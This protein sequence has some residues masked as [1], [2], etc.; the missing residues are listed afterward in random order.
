MFL[1]QSSRNFLIRYL[2][3]TFQV[4]GRVFYTDAGGASIDTTAKS[5]AYLPLEEACIYRIRH[6]E[7][8]G[9]VPGIQE[10]F[11]VIGEN[12]VDDGLILSLRA[13]QYEFAWERCRQL[14]AED[15]VVKGKVS[16]VLV[17]YVSICLCGSFWSLVCMFELQEIDSELHWLY[18]RLMCLNFINLQLWQKM[19]I[20][21]LFLKFPT[22]NRLSLMA[23]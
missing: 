13:I 12:E 1:S 14:Q 3:F 19:I 7:E 16:I 17:V 11:V 5:S 21:I 8:A 22:L 10:E 18:L 23:E 20:S 2:Y 9:I 6:V 15:V 4:K